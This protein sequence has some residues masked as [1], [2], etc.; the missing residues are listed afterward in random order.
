MIGYV[1]LLGL[2]YVL[3]AKAGR[4]RYEQIAGTYRALTGSPAAKTVI[5]AGRRKIA[6]RVSPDSGFVTLTEIDTQT[7]VV[8]RQPKAAP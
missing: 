5:D 1:A 2:G 8:E 3:G 4:R 7:V 6:N